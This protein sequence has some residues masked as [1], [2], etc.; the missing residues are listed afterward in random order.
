[1]NEKIL[2]EVRAHIILTGLDLEE[3]YTSDTRAHQ[4]LHFLKQNPQL[5]LLNVNKLLSVCFIEQKFLE[6]TK[7]LR[8]S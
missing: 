1:M 8:K 2:K 5:T 7:I 6:T 4:L 3:C